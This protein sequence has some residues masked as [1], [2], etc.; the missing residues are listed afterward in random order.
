MSKEKLLSHAEL[1]RLLHYDPSTGLFTRL[2]QTTP[3]VKVGD[4]A[5]GLNA[6]GYIQISVL[7]VAFLAHRLAWFY[8]TG[9]W[10]V[11]DIDHISG[12]RD[13]NRWCNLRTATRTENLRNTATRADNTSGHKGVG[14]S[15]KTNQW[16]A[17]IQINGKTKSLGHFDEKQDAILARQTAE[18]LHFGEFVRQ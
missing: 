3:A 11:A 12:V 8:M 17:Y 13:D 16:R 6:H 18:K 15:N 9:A 14:W 7:N 5:G 1:K 2:V 10:P 4:I